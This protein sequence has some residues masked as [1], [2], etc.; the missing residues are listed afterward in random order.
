MHMQVDSEY[1]AGRISEAIE[2][3][4]MAKRLNKIG[5]GLGTLFI[6]ASIV[7]SVS[8]T[9]VNANNDDDDHNYNNYNN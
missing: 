7:A 1:D 9:L 2:A 5:F 3:S 6:V 8:A 4:L